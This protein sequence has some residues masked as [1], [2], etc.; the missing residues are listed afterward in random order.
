MHYPGHTA[1]YGN[2][3]GLTIPGTSTKLSNTSVAGLVV[4]LG[5]GFVVYRYATTQAR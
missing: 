5:L 4:L 2:P 3:Y 1:R